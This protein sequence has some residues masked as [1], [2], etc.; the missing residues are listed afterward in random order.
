LIDFILARFDNFYSLI[1][2][3]TFEGQIPMQHA[4]EYN[5]DC[6]H[7]DA[8]INFII[9]VVGEAFGSHVGE[10]AG[11][12]ILLGEEGDGSGYSKIDYFYF[13]LFGVYQ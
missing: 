10:T 13:L 7:I 12:E 8:S 5:S 11:I 1:I 3:P 9:F 4:V 2:V 6:P